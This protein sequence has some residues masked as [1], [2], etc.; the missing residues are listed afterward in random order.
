MV[1]VTNATA[2]K[3]SAVDPHICILKLA[4]PSWFIH[5]FGDL[6]QELSGNAP[7]IANVR[8]LP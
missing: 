3:A 5:P 6:T 1:R 2:A 4:L 8:R 7:S